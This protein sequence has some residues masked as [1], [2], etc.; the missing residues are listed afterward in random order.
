M[1][2]AAYP[3]TLLCIFVARFLGFLVFARTF[4]GILQSEL[5]P[6]SEN[7]ILGPTWGL[8]KTP[9]YIFLFLLGPQITFSSVSGSPSTS[10]SSLKSFKLRTFPSY[11]SFFSL[12]FCLFGDQRKKHIGGTPL[13]QYKRIITLSF[14]I[15]VGQ[16]MLIST[17]KPKTASEMPV[18]HSP[19]K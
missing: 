17:L 6:G 15:N 13:G 14:F 8:I 16:Y 19:G 5:L 7:H 11:G 2:I 12:H 4:T 3:V 18:P 9:G 10:D 1:A